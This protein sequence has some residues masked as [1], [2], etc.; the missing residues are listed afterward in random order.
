V[1]GGWGGGGVVWGGGGGGGPT[2]PTPTHPNHPPHSPSSPPPPTCS[3][4][5]FFF[6]TLMGGEFDVEPGGRD[7]TEN[8]A[9]SA[10]QQLAPRMF[11]FS[12]VTLGRRTNAGRT[13]LLHLLLRR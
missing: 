6:L 11:G 13:V 7:D 5:R 1:G 8:H 2:P 9:P 4:T 12:L 10:K 3:R